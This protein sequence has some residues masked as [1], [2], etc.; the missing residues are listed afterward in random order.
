MITY[1]TNPLTG[2]IDVRLEGKL[3]G[4][5]L[6]HG[7]GWRYKVL[8]KPIYGVTFSTV[9]EVKHSLEGAYDVKTG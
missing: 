7:R 9:Q 1:E 4:F 6:P 2:E 3:A 5:I 8:E